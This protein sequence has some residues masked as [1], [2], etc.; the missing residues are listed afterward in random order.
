M[1]IQLLH[2][3][4][5]FGSIRIELHHSIAFPLLLGMCLLDVPGYMKKGD[6]EVVEMEHEKGEMQIYVTRAEN[7]MH[8]PTST[9]GIITSSPVVLGLRDGK[10][11]TVLCAV[12]VPRLYQVQL[13]LS[14]YLLSQAMMS[15]LPSHLEC[16]ETHINSR[17]TVRAP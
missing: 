17:L 6:V 8:R 14:P 9:P 16:G 2:F 12:G 1:G 4:M 10:Y 5:I 3:E 15:G 13:I 11:D 7:G